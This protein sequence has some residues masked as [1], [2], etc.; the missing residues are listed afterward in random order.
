MLALAAAQPAPLRRSRS[1]RR[2]VS[3]ARGR[4]ARCRGT[5]AE[6]SSLARTRAPLRT[7]RVVSPAP[8]IPLRRRR[9]RR[10]DLSARKAIPA[11]SVLRAQV[12]AVGARTPDRRLLR[13]SSPRAQG[14]SPGRRAPKAKSALHPRTAATATAFHRAARKAVRRS[15]RAEVRRAHA[16]VAAR[17]ASSRASG[18]ERAGAF[19]AGS[20]T[21]VVSGA[22]RREDMNTSR[23]PLTAR[24]TRS[25][26]PPR[27]LA[28]LRESTATRLGLDGGGDRRCWFWPGREPT[29]RRREGVRRR[30]TPAAP[31]PAGSAPTPRRASFASAARGPPPRALTTPPR[32]RLARVAE[33][34]SARTSRRHRECGCLSAASTTPAQWAARRRRRVAWPFATARASRRRRLPIARRRRRTSTAPDARERRLS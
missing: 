20:E 8:G 2:R 22:V 1:R 24:T 6:P 29:P 31:P 17:E 3:S 9:H 4:R 16:G 18:R 26:L 34:R 7:P 23:A 19:E 21:R 12:D 25:R 10:R 33:C 32:V 14:R 15:E 30:L 28:A 13:E 11:P 27:L 5:P